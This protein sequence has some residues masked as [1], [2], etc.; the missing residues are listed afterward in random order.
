MYQEVP[1]GAAMRILDK[2][3]N[4][5]D[6]DEIVQRH[7]GIARGKFMFHTTC[8][9]ITLPRAK[10]AYPNHHSATSN[11]THW[12]NVSRASHFDRDTHDIQPP[13]GM[14]KER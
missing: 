6:G 11:R 4:E 3:R 14:I 10:S 7:R 9:D 12:L 8:A 2:E 13:A 1:V 5:Y